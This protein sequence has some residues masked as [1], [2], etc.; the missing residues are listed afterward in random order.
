MPLTDVAIRGFKP[1][2]K[3]AKKSDGGGLQLWVMPSGS[4]L[5]CLAY[6]DSQGKFKKLSFGAYPEVTLAKAREKREAAK[7]LLASGL[8]PGQH[9]KTEKAHKAIAE[10]HT[11]ALIAA[12]L[13]D[14]KRRDGRATATLEKT[15]WM[16]DFALPVIGSRPI[17]EITAPEIL[18]VLRSVE[19]RGRYETAK[20]LR[21]VIGEVFRYAI[22][23]TR[24]DTDPTFH[25][26]GALTSPK[27][28]HRAAITEAKALGGLMRAIDAFQGQ[29]TTVAAL[30]LMALLFP[31]PGELR[32]AEWKELDVENAVWIIPAA[33]MKMRR[34]H[35]VPLPPQALAVLES[36]RPI[37]GHGDLVFPGIVSVKKPISENTMNVALRRMGYGQDEMTAHGFRAAASTLLNESGKFSA[38]AIERALAHQDKDAIRRTYARGEYWPERMKMAVWWADYL[39][40]LRNGAKVMP[41]KR[42]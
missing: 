40:A 11:F 25:L 4:K 3:V 27:V 16:L 14:K 24:A 33:R 41:F 2:Q 28:T 31:R 32:L 8:D 15:E 35:R 18:G 38:D 7:V 13:I 29:P 1:G 19:V 26:R 12:E 39:D 42:A 10:A 5:W 30:K 34:E 17:K 22:S 9:K 20:R 21:A 6:R 23:T 36:L 37:T